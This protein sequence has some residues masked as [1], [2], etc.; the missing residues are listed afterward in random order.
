MKDFLNSN[1]ERLIRDKN[2]AV[3]GWI[4]FRNKD[5]NKQ[6]NAYKQSQE[7]NLFIQVTD[8][9]RKVIGRTDNLHSTLPLGETLARKVYQLDNV[10][11]T[12]YQSSKYGNLLI[13][14]GTGLNNGIILGFVQV[15]IQEEE[16]IKTLDRVIRWILLSIPILL[17]MSFVLGFF[18]TKT[19]IAPFATIS[20]VAKRISFNEL[21]NS[22]LPIVNPHDELGELT[23]TINELLDRLNDAVNS[24][25]QF[26]ADAAHELRTPL[27]IMQSEIEISLREK[28]TNIDIQ[29]ILK[30]NLE[31]VHR[32]TAITDNL[33][34][35]T[36]FDS[37][38]GIAEKTNVDL[39]G[40]CQ[41]VVGRFNIALTQNDIRF[42]I[43]GDDTV[44]IRGNKAYLEQMFINI[45]DNSIKYSFPKSNIELTIN[46][47]NKGAHVLLKDTGIGIPQEEL[48]FIFNRFYR[49]D[50]SRSSKIPGSGLG[51]A[52]VKSIVDFHQGSIEIKSE[53]G[54]GTKIF[55]ELP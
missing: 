54:K 55:I 30:S 43:N 26:V 17:F 39:K 20:G 31:E 1:A 29:Q 19:L 24:Q 7:A 28:T 38:K 2:F 5:M 11:I 8:L 44:F 6:V 27:A 37:N 52:I 21:G 14:N 51:L 41:Q 9:N 32:L 47:F 42:D 22:R 49:V 40:M 50:K 15:A 13:A 45:I 33:I 18:L 3:G 53:L 46:Q 35:L 25:Q 12:R 10:V 36:R 4:D 16:I 34:V 48:P 23:I